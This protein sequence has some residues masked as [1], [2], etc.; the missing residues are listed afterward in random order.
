MGEECASRAKDLAKKHRGPRQRA[1]LRQHVARSRN[2]EEDCHPANPTG[3]VEKV[4]GAKGGDCAPVFG[5]LFPG[6]E[7][8]D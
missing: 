7:S 6:G 1:A 2:G 8:S 4:H 3:H 5:N